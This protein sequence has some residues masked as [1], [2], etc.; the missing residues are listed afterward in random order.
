MPDKNIGDPGQRDISYK[1]K[2]IGD[3]G[4]PGLDEDFQVRDILHAMIARGDKDLS[5]PHA[6]S[7]YSYMIGKYGKGMAD[8]LLTHALMFN[9]RDD[10][11][12]KPFP[13]RLRSFYTV[14]ANDPEVDK[15]IKKNA[16][17][18]Y[19]AETELTDAPVGEIM[20]LTGRGLSKK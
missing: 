10:V 17:L 2:S 11:Q 7:G 1:A 16:K 6:K 13:D 12:N 18:G 19:G 20:E 4:K 9:Q 5:D 3:F 15:L 14:G 8:K